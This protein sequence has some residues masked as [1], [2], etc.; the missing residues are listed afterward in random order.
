MSLNP[1]QQRFV[2][3]YLVDLNAK[4][5]A[6]RAGYSEKTAEVQ[7]C[8]LLRNAQ[9]TAEIAKRQA[10]RAERIEVDA[11]WVLARLVTVTERCMQSAPV[12]DRSGEQVYVETPE[13]EVVPAFTFDAKGANGALGLI[14]RHLGMFNDKLTVDF[15]HADRVEAARRR[16]LSKKEKAE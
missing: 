3:E 13:G 14:G 1:K 15:T 5:A 9:V 10:E 8:R 2:E 16:A 7:G 11:D 4:Q 6:I 12:L